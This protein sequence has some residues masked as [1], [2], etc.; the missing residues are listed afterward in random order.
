MKSNGESEISALE[1]VQKRGPTED[2]AQQD[3]ARGHKTHGLCELSAHQP[4]RRLHGPPEPWLVEVR[5]HTCR[6]VAPRDPR[7]VAASS[8]FRVC[9]PG[10][11]LPTRPVANNC[12]LPPRLKP[13]RRSTRRRFTCPAVWVLVSGCTALFLALPPPFAARRS[14]A[15]SVSL[16]TPSMQVPGA[17]LTGR[18]GGHRRCPAAASLLFSLGVPSPRSLRQPAYVSKHARQ[19][20]IWVVA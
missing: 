18:P 17:A 14:R 7:H 9:F 5:L 11:A 1:I 13:R 10:R 8:L 12:S 6:Y 15:L 3:R 16:L 4:C 2:T 19:F 20:P